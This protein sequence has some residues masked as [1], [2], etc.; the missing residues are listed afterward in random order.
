MYSYGFA[1]EVTSTVSFLSKPGTSSSDVLT[2]ELS[3]DGR[4]T[5]AFNQQ[6][7]TGFSYDARGN[8]THTESYSFGDGGGLVMRTLPGRTINST[9]TFS[10]S[11]DMAMSLVKTGTGEGTAAFTYDDFGRMTIDGAAGTALSY[12]HLDLPATI[13][14][15]S[16]TT[17][18]DYHYLADGM[19]TESTD[20]NGHGLAY[21]G[22]FTRGVSPSRALKTSMINAV[23]SFKR[24]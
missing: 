13:S 15:S 14:S 3:Y 17:C 2:E 6:G 18:A 5:G 9:E 22:P 16:G 21:R 24:G 8:V 23:Q 19:K 10:H 4:V 11:G 12:N 20:G 1:V 7:G